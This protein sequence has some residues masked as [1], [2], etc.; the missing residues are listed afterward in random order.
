MLQLEVLKRRV[1]GTH[2]VAD[3][4]MLCSATGRRNGDT[5]CTCCCLVVQAH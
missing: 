1:K 2:A 5:S 4:V 3:L